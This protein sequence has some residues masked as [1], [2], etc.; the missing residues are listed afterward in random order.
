MGE[1]KLDILDINKNLSQNTDALSSDGLHPSDGGVEIFVQSFRD[2]FRSSDFNPN[3]CEITTRPR[4]KQTQQ[5]SN[6]NPKTIEMIQFFQNGAKFF[7]KYYFR[8]FSW[9]KLWGLFNLFNSL[10]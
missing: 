6:L 10:C 8:I 5:S 2:S 3:T 9:C 4:M 7:R 1:V